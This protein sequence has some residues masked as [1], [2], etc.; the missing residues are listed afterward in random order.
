MWARSLAEVG[1]WQVFGSV[2]TVLSSG[3]VFGSVETV[4]SVCT[5]LSSRAVFGVCLGSLKTWRQV[6]A[7][8]L[9]V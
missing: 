7:C 2:E 5:V 3:A 1:L 9:A 8:V 6:M 4:Y